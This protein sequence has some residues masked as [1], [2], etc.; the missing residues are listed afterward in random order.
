MRSIAIHV[1]T[2][3][4]SW[5][6]LIKQTERNK[7]PEVKWFL[8]DFEV[9]PVSSGIRLFFFCGTPRDD[10]ADLDKAAKGV[11][12]PLCCYNI[13]LGAFGIS[14]NLHSVVKSFKT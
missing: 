9:S 12:G 4:I 5:Q 8:E 1:E 2:F 13:P 10:N 3:Y 6:L 11:A 14:I 7:T